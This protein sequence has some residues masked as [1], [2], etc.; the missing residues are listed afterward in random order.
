MSE[1]TATQVK[2]K[3]NL[4]LVQTISQFFWKLQEYFHFFEKSFF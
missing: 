4:K 2:P 3:R 1:G